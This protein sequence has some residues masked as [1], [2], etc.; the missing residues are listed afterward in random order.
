MTRPR[1]VLPDKTY[2]VTRRCSE[3]RF[4]LRPDREVT[5]IFEYLL[6]IA[7]E[8]FEIDLHAYM[9][10]SNHYHLVLTDRLGN[11][12]DFEQYLNSLL[13]RS[14]NCFRG[15]WE[16]FWDP[17]SFSGVE[18]VDSESRLERVVYTLMNPVDANL[19]TRVEHWEGACSLRMRF[20]VGV[21]V[22]RPD[23]FFS[24]DMPET[25]T[26]K[27]V[28]PPGLEEFSPEL[29][30]RLINERIRK[31][32]GARDRSQKVLGMHR[33]RTQHWNS[34]PDTLEPRRG[35]NPRIAAQSHQARVEAL[36][37]LREWLSSYYAALAHFRAGD[38]DVQ[39][40]RGTYWMCVKLGCPSSAA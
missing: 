3:R 9:V 34:S 23:E 19:V 35:L 31:A 2:L 20:G 17:D 27:V 26:L 7:C 37:T 38:R 22:S 40:P 10:V 12:P 15:R 13:A 32:E 6:A 36:T 5:R 16:S 11:L 30:Q 39:F 29:L 8:R 1:R 25:G 28:P 33:V 18:L 4:F 21:P 24:E 14:I